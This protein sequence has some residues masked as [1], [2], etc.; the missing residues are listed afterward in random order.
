VAYPELAEYAGRTYW[1]NDGIQYDGRSPAH[2]EHLLRALADRR[3]PVIVLP[4]D[5]PPRGYEPAPAIAPATRPPAVVDV[6]R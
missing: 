6:R 4:Y 3:F 1:F 5:Q 2:R